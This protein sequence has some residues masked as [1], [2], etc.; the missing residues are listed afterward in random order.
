MSDFVFEYNIFY[1]QPAQVTNNHI[2]FECRNIPQHHNNLPES[3]AEILHNHPQPLSN[4]IVNSNSLQSPKLK[5]KFKI[6]L[7]YN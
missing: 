2:L 1:A 7:K 6:H 3:L 5:P 4:I